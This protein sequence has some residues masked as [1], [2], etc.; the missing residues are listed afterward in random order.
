MKVLENLAIR[1][2]TK[3][4]GPKY[5]NIQLRRLF[6]QQQVSEQLSLQQPSLQHEVAQFSAQLSLQQPS[7]QHV[8]EQHISSLSIEDVIVFPQLLFYGYKV[9]PIGLYN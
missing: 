4:G 2:G 8:S 7:A 9:L 1:L 6:S 3:I 5:P